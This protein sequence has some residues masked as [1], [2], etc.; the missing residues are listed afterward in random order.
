MKG[1][2]GLDDINVMIKVVSNIFFS[3]FFLRNF[4]WIENDGY[5]YKKKALVYDIFLKEKVVTVKVFKL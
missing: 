4:F 3:F 2:M 5:S 1:Y